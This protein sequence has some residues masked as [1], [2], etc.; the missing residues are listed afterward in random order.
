MTDVSPWRT[1]LVAL[2]GMACLLVAALAHV[3]GEDLAHVQWGLVGIVALV[4]GK[5]LGQYLGAGSG[6]KGALAA[7]TT[8]ARP[9]AENGAQK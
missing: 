2:A 7:L 3:T 4:A 8:D 6:V 1:V 5:S 9:G